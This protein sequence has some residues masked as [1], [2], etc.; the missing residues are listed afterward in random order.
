MVIEL[1]LIH[2]DIRQAKTL[3]GSFYSD[4]RCLAMARDKIFTRSW[5]FVTDTDRLKVPG[6]VLPW[7]A[8]E[9]CLDEPVIFTRDGDDKIHCLGNVCTHRGNLLVEGECHA[10]GLRCRYHGRRFSLDGRFVSAPGFEA[11]INFPTEADDLPRVPFGTWGKFVF[12]SISPAFELEELTGDMQSRLAWLPLDEFVLEPSLSRD[13]LVQANWALYCDNYLE[14]LHIPYVHPGLAAKLDP[15]DYRSELYRYS[16]L[17]I[18]IAASADEAFDLPASL[19]D[20]GQRIAAYYYW[21]F[22]NTMFNFYPWGLSINVVS[23]IAVDRT[24]VSFITYIWDRTKL[25]SGAGGALDRVEREDEDIVEK[26]QKGVRSRFYDRG[27]YSPDW[28]RGLHHFHFLLTSFLSA[29]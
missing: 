3:P 10:Q 9:G 28:E 29:K 18:G 27:R 19:P 6:Q 4:E 7:T 26:V 17:Q 5:Q 14:G 8:L 20:H 16:N 23:P 11:A 12:A 25:G 22:P 15:R 1:T 24:R 2:E 21:L 13:Y